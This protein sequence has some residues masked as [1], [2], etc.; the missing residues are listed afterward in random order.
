MLIGCVFGF[1]FFENGC[2][3]WGG[4]LIL[5]LKKSCEKLGIGFWVKT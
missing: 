2:V 1:D 4:V 5:I 3:D